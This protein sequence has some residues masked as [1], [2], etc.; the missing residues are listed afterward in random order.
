MEGWDI[1]INGNDCVLTE[2]LLHFSYCLVFF[3]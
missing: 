2:L 1:G 3:G